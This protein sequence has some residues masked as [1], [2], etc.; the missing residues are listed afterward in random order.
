MLKEYNG[1]IISRMGRVLDVI[2]SSPLTTFV[3]YDRYIKIEID[4]D[5]TLDEEFNVP[6]N[7]QRVDVSEPIWRILEEAGLVKALDKVRAKR[8]EEKSAYSSERDTKKGE[9]RPSEVAMEQ[10][11]KL[12]PRL[13]PETEARRQREGERRLQQHAEKRSTETGKPVEQTRKEL[14]GELSGRGYSLAKELVPGGNFFRVE[15]IG[16]TKVLFLNTATRFFNEVYAGP[17]SSPTHRWALEV[18]LFA[19]GDRILDAQDEM[20]ERTTTRSPSGRR[21]WSSHSPSYRCKPRP[22]RP[23][24]R[25]SLML[26]RRWNWRLQ[27]RPS[28]FWKTCSGSGLRGPPPND[29]MVGFVGHAR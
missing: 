25:T 28:I 7:K 5:A 21:N 6:T 24:M 29:P 18:L 1:F 13:S 15:Q 9:K 4:F 11:A 23:K 10:A 17:E 16:G 26:P 14:E 27:N 19:I 3:N 20:R 22:L 8:K 12:A 2:R